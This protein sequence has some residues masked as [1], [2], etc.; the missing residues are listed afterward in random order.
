[1]L[2]ETQIRKIP[3]SQTVVLL[4]HGILGTPHQF[5]PFLSVIP[6]DWSMINLLLDGHGSSVE[7]FGHSSMHTWET[8]VAA[9]ID[10]LCSEYKNIFIIAHSMG[11]LFAIDAA[12]AHPEKIRQLL[13]LSPPLKVGPKLRLL[14]YAFRI[15]LGFGGEYDA[16][17]TAVR[18]A[19]SIQTDRRIWKYLPWIPRYL[20]LFAKIR[21]TKKL[22]PSLKTPT[23]V[24]L[25]LDD[26]MVSVHTDRYVKT[27]P[28]CTLHYLS[29][30]THFAYSE[31]DAEHIRNTIRDFQSVK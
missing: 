4:V 21:R 20:E 15:G 12:I 5:D 26:E 25:C 29:R 23:A 16:E 3:G 9:L 18:H 10:S 17:L 13:L 31:A 28:A 19:Y 30:S 27:H 7:N 6:K 1:M 8:Q 24:Y 11:T 14:R 2:H 22:L